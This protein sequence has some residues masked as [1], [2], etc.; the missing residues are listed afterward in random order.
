MVDPATA[1]ESRGYAADGRLVLDVAGDRLLLEAEG[2][3]A[4]CTGTELEPQIELDSSMLAAGYLGAVRF[5][6]LRN[7]RRLRELSPGACRQADLMFAS[8][9]D[10]WCSYEF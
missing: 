3:E 5:S 9:R 1:L 4:R 7:G 6:A 8:Q 2:G 10:P